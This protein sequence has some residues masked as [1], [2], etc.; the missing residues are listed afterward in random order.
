VNKPIEFTVVAK[1]KQG[2]QVK[3]GGAPFI[4][5]MKTSTNNVIDG[6]IKDNEDGTYTVTV[7]PTEPGDAR[8]H[9]TLNGKPVANSPMQINVKPDHVDMDPSQSIVENVTSGPPTQGKPVEFKI[10]AK[11]SQ[12]KPVKNGGEKIDVKIAQPGGFLPAE[13]IDNDDGTY[14][15][16]F[17]PK[18][19]GKHTVTLTS[20]N[21]PLGN[22]P[23]TLSVEESEEEKA[24]KRRE[25]EEAARRKAEE[26]ARRRA[27]EEEAR[28]RA[29][30]EAA[31]RRKAQEDAKRRAEEEARNR[32]EA[33][34]RRIAE[35]EARRRAE[36]EARRRAEEEAARRKHAEEEARRRAEEEAKRKRAQEE[37]ASRSLQTFKPSSK[38][39]GQICNICSKELLQGGGLLVRV[40]G[41]DIYHQNCFVCVTC[42]KSFTDFYWHYQG[43]PYCLNHFSEAQNLWCPGCNKLLD[44]EEAIDALNAVWHPQCFVCTVCRKPF[45]KTSYYDYNGKPYCAVHYGE[46]ASVKCSKCNLVISADQANIK[47]LGKDWHADCFSCMKCNTP[48]LKA[49]FYDIRGMPHCEAHRS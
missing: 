41:K 22:S 10:T 35:E 21:I 46:V 3:Q 4:A 26:E 47:A 39:A 31:R 45:D 16:T 49:K 5:K 12:G 9:V 37:Q 38:Y 48:L 24:R 20:N 40:D 19:P 25:A 33:E 11:D 43:K 6:I 8:I 13:V 27:E 42:K 23:V 15:L 1:D 18:A 17:V 29:E 2:N 44:T 30:E 7:T 14:S 34:A 36:E 32:A 28:R